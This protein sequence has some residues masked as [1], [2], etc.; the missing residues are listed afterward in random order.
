MPQRRNRVIVVAS[1]IHDPYRPYS[2]KAPAQPRRTSHRTTALRLLVDR[3]KARPRPHQGGPAD[4]QWRINEW[5]AVF[6]GGCGFPM[7][8]PAANCCCL[9]WRSVSVFRLRQGWTDAARVPGEHDARWKLIGN[10]VTTGV[11]AWVGHHLTHGG[12]GSDPWEREPI[13]FRRACPGAASGGPGRTLRKAVVS[14]WPDW[15][16]WSPWRA[17]STT[18]DGVLECS[19]CEP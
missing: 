16:L 9:R 12:D 4:P 6:S 11:G 2:G 15:L 5:F 17:L 19:H 7:L 18:R 8:C 13:G 1:N 3:G 14:M 10:A